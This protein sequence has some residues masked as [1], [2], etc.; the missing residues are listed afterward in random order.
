[1]KSKRNRQAVGVRTEEPYAGQPAQAP[2]TARTAIDL[3]LAPMPAGTL[4]AKAVQRRLADSAAA[5]K[6]K[7][8]SR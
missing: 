4:D 5:W 1:M 7:H 3:F 2:A 6:I 8:T